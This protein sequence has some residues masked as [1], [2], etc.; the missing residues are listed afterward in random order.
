MKIK[1]Y[2]ADYY[3]ENR[4]ALKREKTQLPNNSFYIPGRVPHTRSV[5]NKS[6]VTRLR[7]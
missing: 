3:T 5:V 4:V 2:E 6:I 7:L 1:I